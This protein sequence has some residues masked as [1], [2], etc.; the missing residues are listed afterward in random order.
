MLGAGPRTASLD[1]T[2][3]GLTFIYC[4]GLTLLSS[5]S[6]NV[7]LP[8]LPFT[9]ILSNVCFCWLTCLAI[10]LNLVLQLLKYI[11]FWKISPEPF[12]V[13]VFQYFCQ[14]FWYFC[15][16]LISSF[17]N[18]KIKIFLCIYVSFMAQ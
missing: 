9:Y 10:S 11:V 4:R 2:S 5:G 12:S 13:C 1:D 7:A 17:D 18:F 14:R 16:T 8:Q 15:E 6:K 3:F